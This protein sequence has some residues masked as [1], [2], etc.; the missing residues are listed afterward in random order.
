[1]VRARRNH[2]QGVRA[3][4]CPR[5]GKTTCP[6]AHEK[7]PRRVRAGLCK[8]GSAT[9]WLAI[10]HG[11][12][13]EQ[14]AQQPNEMESLEV[15]LW[16]EWWRKAWWQRIAKRVLTQHPFVT[17][18]TPFPP[19]ML[20][21]G[22]SVSCKLSD[23]PPNARSWVRLATSLPPNARSWAGSDCLPNCYAALWAS[24]SRCADWKIFRPASEYAVLGLPLT[25]CLRIRGLGLPSVPC[26]RMR[27]LGTLVPPSGRVGNFN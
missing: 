17:H 16:S 9:S 26:L 5:R 12:S 2:Q 4:P 14:W 20:S 7:K 19:S 18:R 1:M 13:G 3:H 21:V 23:L 15:E 11:V 10:G 6:P 25:S 22:G 24:T 8:A 27:G